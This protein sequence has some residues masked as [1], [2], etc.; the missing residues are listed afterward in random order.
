[1]KILILGGT[2]FVGRATVEVALERGHEVTLF[3]RGR[4]NPGLFPQVEQ[5]QGD[6]DGGLAALANRH[7]DAVIDTCGYVPRVVRQSAEFLAEAV[8]Q[9]LFISSLS[10]YAEPGQP[11]IDEQ[12]AVGKLQDETVEEITGETY[13]PLKVLCEQAV[14]QTLPG[15]AL[16]V[17]PGLIVGPYDRTDRFTYWP[18]RVAQGSEVLA[19]G[20]PG[21]PIQFID[22]RDLADWLVHLVENRQTGVYNAI[23]PEPQP[24][25]GELLETCRS[26]SGSDA[27]L[28]WVS[29]AFLAEQG[30]QPWADLPAWLPQSEPSTAGF[31]AFSN[32]RAVAAGLKFRPLADTIHATLAW[33]A[34]RPPDYQLRAGLSREREAALLAAWKQKE[35]TRA[36]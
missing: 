24:T 29:E 6:R 16:I 31:F 34:T 35:A 28:V 3:N 19:P 27:Q 2:V 4:S 5:L 36:E 30:V 26:A 21:R 10:V 20:Q 9:Y 33:A 12:G 32:R 25:M 15:R 23:G 1:M 22:V 13:G 7:W 18:W 17:R 8:G 11:G 14:E